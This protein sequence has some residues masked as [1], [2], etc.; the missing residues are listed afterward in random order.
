MIK[1]NYH[2]KLIRRLV[3]NDKNLAK[4]NFKTNRQNRKL[5]TASQ[6]GGW[7]PLA[8]GASSIG[9]KQRKAGNRHTDKTVSGKRRIDRGGE[10]TTE[11]SCFA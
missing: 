9:E 1:E 6:S 4:C 3:V 2:K 8:S 10:T 7:V 5:T 11:K